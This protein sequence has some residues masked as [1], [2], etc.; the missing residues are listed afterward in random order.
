M[1]ERF[2]APEALKF[3]LL[4]NVT[5]GHFSSVRALTVKKKIEPI[6]KRAPSKESL[7]LSLIAALFLSQSPAL[8][9]DEPKM[10]LL[11]QKEED[12]GDF[13]VYVWRDGVKVTVTKMDCQVL[14]C[15]PDWKVHCFRDKERIEWVGAMSQFS[16]VVMAN[17]FAVAKPSALANL[18]F[19]GN[20]EYNGLHCAKYSTRQAAKNVLYTARDIPASPKVS[21]FLSRL[22]YLPNMNGVPLYRCSDKGS[23]RRLKTEVI[24]LDVGND[25]RSGL[26]VKLQTN[27]CRQLPFDRLKF[28][29]PRG[30]KRVT[31]VIQ[32]TYSA[33]KK[34]QFVEI[35][36]N[37]GFRT[38]GK[39]EH[40][41]KVSK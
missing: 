20:G 34:D 18:D 28:E 22:Y 36:G 33:N 32:V 25:L 27:S 1:I 11:S 4:G 13:L 6:S 41:E 23:G 26:S 21:E 15:A 10:W 17:P 30:Y 35:F 5:I 39:G 9:K 16:G 29:A 19:V 14:A 7:V 37:V 12:S 3:D 40:D 2:V 31:D 38:S 24:G 8:S